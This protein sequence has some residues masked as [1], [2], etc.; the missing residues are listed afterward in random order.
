MNGAASHEEA[1]PS[2]FGMTA[3][4]HEPADLSIDVVDS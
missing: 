4:R 2:A 1:A 3:T